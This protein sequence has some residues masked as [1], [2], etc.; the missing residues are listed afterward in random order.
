MR[1]YPIQVPINLLALA[2]LLIAGALALAIIA[3]GGGE[4]ESTEA[5]AADVRVRHRDDRVPRVL[6]TAGRYQH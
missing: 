5:T 4:E 6:S 1:P 3:C 2:T